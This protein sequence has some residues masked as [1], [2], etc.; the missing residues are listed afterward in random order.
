MHFVVVAKDRGLA[1]GQIKESVPEACCCCWDWYGKG[2]CLLCGGS[3]L[4]LLTCL[5]AIAVDLDQNE[6]ASRLGQS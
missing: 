3:G 2:G 5:Q 1:W 6:G 4:G